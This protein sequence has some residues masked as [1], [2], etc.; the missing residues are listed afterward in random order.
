MN[1]CKILK[2]NLAVGVLIENGQG[3][4]ASPAFNPST[5]EADLCRFKASLVYIACTR[6]SRAIQ[7]NSVSRI[8]PFNRTF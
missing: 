7:R 1:D 4:M 8:G 5:Q 6:T 3:M 2:S